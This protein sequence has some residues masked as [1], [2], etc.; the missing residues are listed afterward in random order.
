M[1]RRHRTPYGWTAQ[2]MDYHRGRWIVEP[3]V[4][5]KWR[6]VHTEFR[7]FDGRPLW[8]LHPSLESACAWADS[9]E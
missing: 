1:G 8:A 9:V 3:S 5:G 2:G 7:D 4:A 6:A